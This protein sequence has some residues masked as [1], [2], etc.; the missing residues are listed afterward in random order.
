MLCPKCGYEISE[1]ADYCPY[2]GNAIHETDRQ[3]ARSTGS[4]SYSYQS[5]AYQNRIQPAVVSLQDLPPE[6]RPLGAWA[7][8]GWGIL[9]SLPI[10]G[11]IL[12]IVFSCVSGNINRK[13]FARSYLCWWLIAAI[14]IAILFIAGVV[15]WNELIHGRY[16]NI[17]F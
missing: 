13:R 3:A 10:A 17:R 2:C 12:V 4:S 5:S 11:F 9:F 16:F 7:Y 1:N 6:F 14:I 8:V 15:T